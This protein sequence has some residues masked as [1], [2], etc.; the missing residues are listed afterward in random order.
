MVILNDA[1]IFSDLYMIMYI[2]MICFRYV[3]IN[4]GSYL[5]TG[6]VDM[7]SVSAG[8]CRIMC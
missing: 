5:Y 6:S 4:D 3:N 2:L 8:S 7:S 1:F